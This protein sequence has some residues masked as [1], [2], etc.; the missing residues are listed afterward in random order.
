MA[1]ETPA[2][3][4]SRQNP[5]LPSMLC[6]T[7]AATMSAGLHTDQEISARLLTALPLNHTVHLSRPCPC[8]EPEIAGAERVKEVG[9]TPKERKQGRSQV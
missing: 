1:D 5:Y 2:P 3:T 8:L 9:G 7:V 6:L 4:K